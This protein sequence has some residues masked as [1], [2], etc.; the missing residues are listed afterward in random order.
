MLQQEEKCWERCFVCGSCRG[1]LSRTSLGFSCVM[2]QSPTSK[3]MN[4][5]VEEGTEMEAVTRRQTDK[6]T[7]D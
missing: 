5:K 3:D 6:D 4:T 1:I 7:A 2:G